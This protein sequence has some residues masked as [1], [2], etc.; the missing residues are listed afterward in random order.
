ME[1]NF[2]SQAR[3]K[4]YSNFVTYFKNIWGFIK[5]QTFHSAPNYLK[6]TSLTLFLAY[7]SVPV[8]AST[9]QWIMPKV[10]FSTLV[11][12]PL[13][14]LSKPSEFGLENTRNFYLHVNEGID[15]GVWHVQPIVSTS[16][17]SHVE[18]SQGEFDDGRSVFLYL[19]GNSGTR[20]TQ[21]RVELYKIIA[22]QGFHVLAVDYRGY[23]DSTGAPTEDGV[24]ADA[25]FV[26]K[27]L[28]Q[29]IGTRKLYLW[30]HSLGTGIATK[31]SKVLC[32]EGDPPSGMILE[33]PFNNISDAAANHPFGIP[34]K[35]L[36]WFESIFV[37]SLGHQGIYFNSEES[38]ASVTNHITILHAKDDRIVPFKLGEKLYESA[39]SSRTSKT[40]G[41][42]FI[43]FEEE[44]GFGHRHIHA[45][46]ELTE[47][48]QKFIT[49][50]DDP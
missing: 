24:V 42:D 7:V 16:D 49:K 9:N 31:L 20:G 11:Q 48:I 14:D 27:W 2:Y 36:P 25:Y 6:A 21:H 45:A 30:G 34:Y 19:H 17:S 12:W 15:I 8:F 1:L 39:K 10:V 22:S 40:K 18:N 5:D 43:S 38:I 33:S 28:R 35:F 44:R 13:N 3:S 41:I 46:E 47:I 4:V 23:G 50:C 37:D 29:R 26:Y 32:E